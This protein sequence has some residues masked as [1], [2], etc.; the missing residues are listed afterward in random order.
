[1]FRRRHDLVEI[2]LNL[3][4][5]QLLSFAFEHCDSRRVYVALSRRRFSTPLVVMR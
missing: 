4:P 5:R 1:M 2:A 3:S